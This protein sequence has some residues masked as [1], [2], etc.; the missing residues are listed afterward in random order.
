MKTYSEKLKDPRWQKK[1]LEIMDR[2]SWACQDCGKDN[3]TLNVHHLRYINGK[4]PWE[5]KNNYLITLCDSCHA[6]S[7]YKI[8]VV[9]TN[10]DISHFVDFI[11]PVKT[12]LLFSKVEFYKGVTCVWVRSGVNLTLLSYMYFNEVLSKL[13]RYIGL[14]NEFIL[15]CA[16]EGEDINDANIVDCIE[17]FPYTLKYEDYGRLD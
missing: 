10:I 13:K 15:Y 5:Y 7:H 6:I 4:K 11:E 2:D 3:G 14:H 1:R 17:E 8:E 16:N 12:R 9:S